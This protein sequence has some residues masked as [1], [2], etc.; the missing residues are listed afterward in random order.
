MDGRDDITRA[1]RH[2]VHPTKTRADK[3]PTTMNGIHHLETTK[4]GYLTL[5]EF[6]AIDTISI[7]DAFL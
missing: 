2:H 4:V 5:F 1:C 6:K 3:Q 7:S